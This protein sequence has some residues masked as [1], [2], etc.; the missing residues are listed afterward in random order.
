MKTVNIIIFL[1]LIATGC[2]FNEDNRT[3]SNN[4]QQHHDQKKPDITLGASES[5]PVNLGW[6]QGFPPPKEK[7][8]SAHDGSF[9][10]FPAL[11]YSVVRMREF[12]PTTNV[13]RGLKPASPFPYQ[14]DDQIDSIKFTPW[15]Q[16]E[17]MTWIESLLKNYT[18]GIIV[19]HKGVVVYEKYFADLNETRVHAVMSLT[20]SFTGT[21]ASVLVAE[22][23]ID[24]NKRV[25]DYVPELAESAFGDATV[26]QV[27]DMTTGLK[28]S[29]NYA[30]PNAEV[31][32]FSAAG[33]PLPKPKDYTGPVGYY[34]Y[35]QTVEK[36]GEHGEAFGYKTVNSDALGWIMARASG[37]SVA[38]L[39]EEKIWTKLGMEQDSYFQID[40]LGTPFAGG[41]FNAGLRDLARFGELIRRKGKWQ[42]Q[43]VIPEQAVLDIEKGSDKEAF[44]KSNYAKLKGWSYRNMWW[45]THNEH[46]AFAARGVHGQTIY[47]DPAAEMVIVR[48]ASHPIAGNAANDPFSLP[49]YHA[50]AK[51]L[52]N[53]NK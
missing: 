24:E 34:E 33:N 51:Y 27:M 7:R 6:M 42:N 4:S 37:K 30:D 18:D 26:R 9:F 21:L 2:N 16:E 45:I 35:L 25:K 49:A 52:I 3:T 14:I 50:L 38:S 10:Q 46:G 29:E 28:Y 43:Q 47:I 41:G 20:K 48:L 23:L 31:W 19:L 12:L 53:D 15:D 1:V 36:E 8:L 40:T 5:E 44:A 32:A 11:R 22:G 13:S 17:P 39:L